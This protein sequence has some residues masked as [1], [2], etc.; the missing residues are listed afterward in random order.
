MAII[1]IEPHLKHSDRCI[2]RTK[3]DLIFLN[4]ITYKKWIAPSGCNR[5]RLGY[6]P[7]K[8]LLVIQLTKDGGYQIRKLVNGR[9]YNISA[10]A[11]MRH[12]NIPP[13]LTTEPTFDAKEKM[14]LAPLA[15][16]G[17]QEK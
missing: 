9:S 13:G 3:I 11:I 16:K 7:D 17:L 4:E 10:R 6:D 1:F 14:I 15:G 8:K 2:I 5:A 12:F